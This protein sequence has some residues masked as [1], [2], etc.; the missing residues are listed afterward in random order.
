VSCD[1]DGHPEGERHEV[2]EHRA[3]QQGSPETPHIDLEAGQEQQERQ[4]DH[5]QH[6]HRQVDLDPA[7]HRRAEHDSGD[8]LE[9][10]CRQPQSRRESE[11][12]RRRRGDQRHEEQVVERHI[13]HGTS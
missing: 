8:Q 9:H 3:A 2:A 10:H 5:P 1:P 7:E 13:G 11:K 6:L 12:Q 4:A